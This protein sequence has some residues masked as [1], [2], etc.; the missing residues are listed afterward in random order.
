[1][2]SVPLH[3][4]KYYTI[5]LVFG[6]QD[7][8]IRERLCREANLT[9][10]KTDEICRATE[11]MKIVGD[12]SG[13]TAVNVIKTIKCLRY[14]HTSDPCK[15]STIRQIRGSQHVDVGIV[16]KLTHDIAIKESCPAY[17]KECKRCHKKNHF[18][19]KCWSKILPN[20]R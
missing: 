18:A 11:S 14:L 9:L 1:M 7:D 16:D 2:T 12:T 13:Q 20:Q 15:A 6:I 10:E 17:G 19:S 3:P 5:Q 4:R 8:K